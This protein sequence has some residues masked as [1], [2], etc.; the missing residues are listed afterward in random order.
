M[1]HASD[2]AVQR[3]A[4]IE[5]LR[6]VSHRLAKPLAKLRVDLP[7]GT[8]VEVDG[9][10]AD[11]SVFAEAFARQ[12]GM[13]GGQKRK[14]ALD[15]L[16]LITLRRVYPSAQ[17]VLAF[18]DDAAVESL[19]GWIAEA[20]ETWNVDRMVVPLDPGLRARLIEVQARQYR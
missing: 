12:G 13:K 15:V 9:A 14:V 1:P 17:L 8:W 20:I 10:A 16:K 5:I 3:E 4:E 2:S 6:G 18:C 19:T 7:G 11:L